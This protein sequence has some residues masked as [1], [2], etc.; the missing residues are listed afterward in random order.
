VANCRRDSDVR[1][2]MCSRSF[3]RRRVASSDTADSGRNNLPLDVATEDADGAPVIGGILLR[4]NS[5]SMT[6][7]E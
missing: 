1:C 3:R 7:P 5:E 4:W 2:Q 6:T